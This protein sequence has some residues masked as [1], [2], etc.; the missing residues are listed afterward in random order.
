M[1]V[2]ISQIAVGTKQIDS[3]YLPSETWVFTLEDG[4]TIEKK[5]VVAE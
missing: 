4:S 3:K 5:V 1:T 2:S